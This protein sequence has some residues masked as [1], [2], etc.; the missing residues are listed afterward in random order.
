MKGNQLL[1]DLKIVVLVTDQRRIEVIANG[2][3][4][5]GV[6]SSWPLTPQWSQHCL[7]GV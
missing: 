5:S 2:V 1:R 3:F 4:L 6:A 7:V